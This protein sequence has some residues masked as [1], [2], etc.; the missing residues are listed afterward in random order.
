MVK[1]CIAAV[2]AVGLG[3]VLSVA[4]ALAQGAPAVS[5]TPVT[6]PAAVSPTPT[7]TPTTPTPGGVPGTLRED[8]LRVPPGSDDRFRVPPDEIRS[9]QQSIV[10]PSPITV[11]SQGTTTPTVGPP[12]PITVP[13]QSSVSPNPGPPAPITVPSLGNTTPNMGP[14]APRTVPSQ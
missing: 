11:P 5:T 12:P 4:C 13:S 1:I 14:P 3:T 7:P 8:Q 9:Q 2:L 6:P 10:P